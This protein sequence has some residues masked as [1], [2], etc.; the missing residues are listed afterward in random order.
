MAGLDT[1][2]HDFCLLRKTWMPGTSPGMTETLA[3]AL[4]PPVRIEPLFQALPAIR[5]I[6]LQRARLRRM[7]GDA[8]RVAGLEHEGH[9]AGQLDRLQLAVAGVVEGFTVGAVRQHHVVQADSTGGK[10][11]RLGI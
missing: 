3:R 7:R 2:I 9:G 1:A 4:L 6:V 5:V 10:S 11:L 8:L